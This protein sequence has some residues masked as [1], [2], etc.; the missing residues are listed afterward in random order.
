MDQGAEVDAIDKYDFT[1][2]MNAAF[3]GH[4]HFVDALLESGADVNFQDKFGCTALTVA[5]TR[6]NVEVV[7]ALLGHGDLDINAIDNHGWTALKAAVQFGRAEAV[8]A[9]LAVGAKVDFTDK[10]GMTA[11][12]EAASREYRGCECFINWC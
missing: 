10:K 12:M 7:N 11:L 5:A 2:L 6:G 3:F 8:K 9:L 1:A 4:A